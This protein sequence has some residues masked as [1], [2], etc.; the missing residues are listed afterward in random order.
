MNTEDQQQTLRITLEELEQARPRPIARTLRPRNASYGNVA[1][2]VAWKNTALEKGSILFQAWFYLGAGGLVGALVA[3]ALAEPGFVDGAGDGWGNV[4][5][6]PTVVSL[7]CVGFIVAEGL[8]ER[9][10][11]KMLRRALLSLFLG[12]VLGFLLNRLGDIIFHI[13]LTYC[14]AAALKADSLSVWVARGL[15]WAVLGIAGGIVYGVVGQSIRKAAYGVLGGAL[16][17]ALGGVIFDPIALVTHGGAPSRAIGF[18]LLG[19]TTGSAMGLVESA[20]KNRW[21]YVT[22][23]PLAGKQF[24]LYKSVTTIGSDHDCDIYLFKDRDIEPDHAILELR[25]SCL[26]LKA[27]GVVTVSG[28]QVR[29]E[30]M[31]DSGAEIQIGRYRFLYQE[32]ER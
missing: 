2:S 15:A 21:L 26:Y 6:I 17:A 24:I 29:G 4:W 18:C 1:R 31:I 32:K 9:A 28:E 23:G 22:V 3:W 5:L 30:Q 25:A 27:N 13:A 8:L 12:A 20:F 11:L 14:S 19:L 16:G 7:M 10:S